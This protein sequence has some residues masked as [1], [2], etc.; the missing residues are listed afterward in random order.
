SGELAAPLKSLVGDSTAELFQAEAKRF[1]T[2]TE[3]AKWE[4]GDASA[5]IDQAE[6]RGDKVLDVLQGIQND[7]N[8]SASAIIGRI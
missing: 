1:E 8:S 7:T 5:S 4:A 3:Q 2:L 6:R